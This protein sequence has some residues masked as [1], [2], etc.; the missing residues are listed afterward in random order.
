VAAGTD[1]DV[2]VRQHCGSSIQAE[3]TPG[4]QDREPNPDHQ[5]MSRFQTTTAR[6][7]HLD[8]GGSIMPADTPRRF[9]VG[10]TVVGRRPDS[11]FNGNQ[12]A[13]AGHLVVHNGKIEFRPG[14]IMQRV[15][16]VDTVVHAD[17]GVKVIQAIFWVPWCNTFLFV[18]DPQTTVRVN[19]PPFTRGS[20]YH[21]VRQ[22]GFGFEMQRTLIM[23]RLR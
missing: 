1:L 10:A 8:S 14:A 3:A 9:R 22:A 20:V 16:G 23:P 15:A 17:A 5:R 7:R 18:R 19:L 13:S 12:F 21:A 6:A 2:Q 4:V 11:I